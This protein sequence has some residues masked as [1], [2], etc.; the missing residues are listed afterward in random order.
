MDA[1]GAPIPISYGA[2]LSGNL[3][4][5]LR[6]GV[7]NLQTRETDEFLGRIILRFQSINKSLDDLNS[8]DISITAKVQLKTVMS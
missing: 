5:D 8:K 4:K 6:I 7:M 2:R 1:D 3:N